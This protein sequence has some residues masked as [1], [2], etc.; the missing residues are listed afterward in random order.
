MVS[1]SA[2]SL[3]PSLQLGSR[4]IYSLTR[5]HSPLTLFCSALLLT[6]PAHTTP[7]RPHTESVRAAMA[8]CAFLSQPRLVLL[9]A[10]LAD[11]VAMAMA[12]PLLGATADAPTPLPAEGPDGVARPAGGR[13]DRSIAGAEVIL[14]G[15]A[16]AV[17]AVI[18]LYIRV[19][20]KSNDRAAAGMAGKA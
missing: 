15:F 8:R 6:S 3:T 11:V 17:M 2:S 10:V 4:P 16:A 13:H 20:R 14:A 5:T 19:T 18:F 9:L 12:R 1:N 7:D